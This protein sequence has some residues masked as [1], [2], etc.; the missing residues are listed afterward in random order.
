MWLFLYYLLVIFTTN[1]CLSKVP[2]HK[3]RLSTV[4]ITFNGQQ[5]RTDL[6]TKSLLYRV[7]FKVE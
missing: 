4:W 6:C 7:R 2:S 1:G 3:K 5:L